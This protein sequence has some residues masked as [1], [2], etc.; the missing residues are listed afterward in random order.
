MTGRE[1][2]VMYAMLRGIPREQAHG[3]VE[4]LLEE[5]NLQGVADKVMGFSSLALGR[6]EK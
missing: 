4:Q 2:L 1:H 3:L 6:G 5:L